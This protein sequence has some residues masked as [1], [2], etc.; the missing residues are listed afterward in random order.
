MRQHGAMDPWRLSGTE[1]A[2]LVRD[3]QLSAR[4]VADSHI[5]RI[6]TVNETLNAIVLR[7]DH[8]GRDCAA[9][10]D[11]NPTGAL[12]GV[13]V[14][15]KINTDHAPYPT[16]NGIKALE[17][18]VAARIHPC[19]EGLLDSGA[20]MLGRTNSPAFAMRAHTENELHGETLNPHRLDISSGGSS[21][22]AA[23]AVATGMCQIAQGNDVAGSVRWP[24]HQN[25]V[26][27]LRPTVGR[28]PSGGT[29]SNPRGWSATN[30]STQGP[31][32]R[33]MDDIEAG[34]VAMRDAA[35]ATEPNWVPARNDFATPER[36]RVAVVLDDG[37]DLDPVVRDTVR[38]TADIFAAAGHDVVESAP[39]MQSEFFTLWKRLGVLDMILGL[40]AMLPT[41]DD[42]GLTTAWNNW[43][44]S[45]PPA[46][47]DV[48]L[49]ALQDRDMV[50]RAWTT[51]LTEHDVLVTPLMSTLT[52]PRRGDIAHPD[53]MNDFDQIGRWGINLSA[54]GVPALAFPVGS[55]EGI[56]LGVQIVAR[57]WRE[58]LLIA[59]GHVLERDLGDV[60]P[61]DPTW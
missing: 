31:I 43:K 57:A 51:F 8:D 49:K 7:T 2:K 40:V 1:T 4:E 26:I 15:T 38:R 45:F 18:N 24:A 36:L 23:V 46:T 25:G 39:P 29:N 14:T 32:A 52:I 11:Q 16:T 44:D 56:P 19:I 22:G 41:I 61:V 10:V 33:T 9:R 12:A 55:H 17:H 3:R 42:A 6:D 27:G 60:R 37:L 30:M 58:D 20:L 47:G 48:F 34:Y 54:I 53:A 21:G 28:I 35:R 5:A 59:A 13:A 50:M